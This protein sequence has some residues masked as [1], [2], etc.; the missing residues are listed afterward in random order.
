[1]AKSQ[2]R[3][4]IRRAL[5]YSFA[6]APYVF[7][8]APAP[9][10]MKAPEQV[11]DVSAAWDQIISSTS[12]AAPSPVL[13]PAQ[14]GKPLTGASD[15]LAHFFFDSRTV[16]EHDQTGFTGLPTN[17]SVINTGDTGVFNPAGI[18][19]LTAF[20][21]SANRIDEFL[22]FGTNG[23]GSDRVNTHFS[24]RYR[25]DLT[26]VDTGT[27]SANVIETFNGNRLYELLDATIEINGKPTDGKFANTSFQFGRLNQYGAEL[28]AFDGGSGTIRRKKW[29]LTLFGGRRFDYFSD[30]KQRAIGG[31]NLTL[32]VTPTFSAEFET[33]WYIK[34]TNKMVLRKRFRD[35]FLVTSYL[36]SY[37][38]NLADIE[39]S[40]L[41]SSRDGRN[42]LRGGYF[43]KVTN[44]DYSYDYT[45]AAT[46]LNTNN[47]LY[48]L[49]LGPFAPYEQFNVDVHRQLLSNLR[50]GAE[51]VMRHI[52]MQANQSPFDTSFQ[53]YKFNSQYFPWK[54]IETDFEYHQRNSDRLSP[55]GVTT[56]S[57]LTGTGETSVKDLT[58]EIRR[59]FGEGRFNL[60]G[61]VYYRR[62]SMQDTFYY[63]TNL[64]Q[65]GVLGSAWLRVDR[66]TRISFDYSLDNDFFLLAPDLKNSTMVRLGLYWKY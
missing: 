54:K 16:Y 6:A 40:A 45:T 19:S 25:Q 53:D 60:S 41:Y 9:T 34:G 61:G 62:I 2:L 42:T 15:F 37:G 55:L 57:N 17:A 23:Y 21:P 44:A 3:G 51:V 1:M 29:D 47:T 14:A 30:P 11:G 43:L 50:A 31:A 49:Y 63:L 24:M 64:H 46:D 32:K 18:P 38:G 36:R 65:S 56:L 22:D 4:L 20:E 10:P 8:Q 39:A 35:R 5:L 27:E 48:R 52:D 26:H 58:G 66:R 12:T 7:A 33:L 59:S 13:M 28:A